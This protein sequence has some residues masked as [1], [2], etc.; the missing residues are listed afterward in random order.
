MDADR[1]LLFAVLALQTDCI[2]AVQF[3][4]ACS[5]WT[6]GR[7]QPMADLLVGR[8]WLTLDDRGLI[9]RLLERKLSR[10][11]GDA[12]E[13]LVAAAKT[14][15]QVRELVEKSL[16]SIA[17]TTPGE[18]LDVLPRGGRDTID[19]VAT[20]RPVP[21]IRDRYLLTTMHAKGGIGQVWLARDSVLDREVALKEL[22]PG[23]SGDS[24]ILTRFLREA[25]ITG[26]AGP[27]GG[28]PGLRIRSGRR[29]QLSPLLH[30]EV[31]PG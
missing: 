2:D 12:H 8:G 25:R 16:E 18:A 30:D 20:I 19:F 21:E 9:E 1:N 6:V 13:S 23:A 10:H 4:Q 17:A 26:G 31:H 28:S 3:A 5:A 29:R 7:D 14:D 24:A 22:Q 27:P 15:A 11:V